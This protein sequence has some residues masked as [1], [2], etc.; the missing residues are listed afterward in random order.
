M[1]DITIEPILLQ[2]PKE[3]YM[4]SL[5]EFSPDGN[6]VKTLIEGKNDVLEM[7]ELMFYN[8]NSN[9]PQH[10]SMPILCGYTKDL[11][12]G[13]FMNHSEWGPCYVELD[14]D[15][16][17]KLFVFKLNDGLKLLAGEAADAAKKTIVK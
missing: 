11:N 3:V 5:F 17:D 10:L 8:V 2:M 16:P 15:Y 6:W 14:V 12:P 7:N 1:E 13:A 4:S 9:Y